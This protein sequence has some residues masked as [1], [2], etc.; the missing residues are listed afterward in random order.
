[1][2]TLDIL[3]R[4]QSNAYLFGLENLGPFV[5]NGATTGPLTGLT[6]TQDLVA[7]YL[8]GSIT[9]RPILATPDTVAPGETSMSATYVNSGTTTTVGAYTVIAGTQLEEGTSLVPGWLIF[10][11]GTT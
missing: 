1:M 9:V 6:L 2:T 5:I 10:Q 8:G 4:G 7:A 3:L 11:P